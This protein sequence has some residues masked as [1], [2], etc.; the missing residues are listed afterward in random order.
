[1]SPSQQ[2]LGRAMPKVIPAGREARVSVRGPAEA[3]LAARR[4]YA[5][6]FFS[7]VNRTE[8]VTFEAT[9]DAGGTLRL[10]LRFASAGEYVLDVLAP[11][12]AAVQSG[13]G[14]APPGD[15]NI[16]ATERFF[17]LPSDLVALRPYKGDVHVHTLGSDGKDTP[18]AMVLA[19]RRAGLDFLAITDHDNYL[20]SREAADAAARMGLDL[21]VIP[22]EEV[23]LPQSG[24]HILALATAAGTSALR[25]GPAAEE[26]LAR[27]RRDQPAGRTLR[28]PLTPEQYAHAVWTVRKIHELGGLAVLAHPYWEGTSRKY[29]P[30]PAMTEQVLEDRLCDAIELVGGSPSVEGNRLAIARYVE[31]AGRGRP[32]P[33]VGGSDAHRQGDLGGTYWTVVFAQALTAEAIVGAIAAA[34]SVACD[35]KTGPQTAIYGPFA[36]VEYAYF[37]DR[38]F[39]PLHDRICRAQASVA[40]RTAADPAADGRAEAEAL[41]RDL[42]ELYRR[43]WAIL[44]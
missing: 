30:P 14:A 18:A 42:A 21:L 16:L 24:G 3:P 9:T 20:P 29:Y 26:E 43:F 34:R 33:V 12:S 27:I 11:G 44:L 17:A 41:R 2:D 36:L 25:K 32:W 35:R 28:A 39:F 1:M 4:T 5:V 19:A 23:T 10:P 38:E 8:D 40:G 15:A 37:L 13:P 6:R 31:E 22:G 7:K